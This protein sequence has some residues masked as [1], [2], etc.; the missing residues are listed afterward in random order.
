M[1][2][3]ID[4]LV[5]AVRS[6]EE[7]AAELEGMLGLAFTGG[8]RHEAFGTWNRL[9]FLGDT[10]FEL[11][12]V[13]DR[14][15]V[16]A[17]P[18]FAVGAAA[19]R[20]LDQAGEGLVTYALASD[21]IDEDVARL[22]DEGSAISRPVAGSRTRSDGEVVRWRTAFPPSLGPEEPPFLI[23]HELAGAE[24]GDAARQGR[25]AF[26]HPVGG[27]VRLVSLELPVRDPEP[28]AERYGRI[29]GIALSE[30]WRV[31]VGGQCIVL[32]GEGGPAVA[33]LSVEPGTPPLDIVRF[34]VRWRR[35]VPVDE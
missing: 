20:H 28:V 33:E 29:L 32:A 1:L 15:L 2:L 23:E 12:G 7:A 25:A 34:G 24:W 17:N 27:A 3:G 10:Y 22:R 9:A 4:H 6:V 11:I 16:A 30:R 5:I 35:V 13:L 21:A 8:G 19:L 31:A 18:A 26:R 14:S